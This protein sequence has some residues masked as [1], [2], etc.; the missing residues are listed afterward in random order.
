VAT[1]HAQPVRIG[2]GVQ[3]GLVPQRADGL[4]DQQVRIDLLGDAL[5]GLGAQHRPWATLVGL[6]LVQPPS[7]SHRW[8]YRAASSAAGAWPGS[9]IEVTSRERC[10]CPGRPGSSMG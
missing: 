6:E 2:V 9:R 1:R 10:R 8:C 3:G 5:R 7:S 4:V